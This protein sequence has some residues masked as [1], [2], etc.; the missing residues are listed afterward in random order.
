MFA[1]LLLVVAV[2]CSGRKAMSLTK[3][4]K[5]V[6]AALVEMS[7]LAA[8]SPGTHGLLPSEVTIALKVGVTQSGELT[9]LDIEEISGPF[10]KRSTVE[11]N[12]IVITLK[13]LLFADHE[14]ILALVGQKKINLVRLLRALK[15]AGLNAPV[16]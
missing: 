5:D 6:D 11:E 8:K 3:A 13:S 7:K 14:T 12:T 15:E 2:G 16:R 4:V 10:F 1:L 9:V